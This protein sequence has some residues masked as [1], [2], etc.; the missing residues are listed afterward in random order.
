MPVFL[1]LAFVAFYEGIRPYYLR[2]ISHF[3]EE[4]FSQGYPAVSAGIYPYFWN[5]DT[6]SIPGAFDSNN[7]EYVASCF[8]KFLNPDRDFTSITKLRLTIRMSE[9]HIFSKTQS[10][11]V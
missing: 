2:L 3:S 6:I 4:H 11:G 10:N 9:R 1:S 8:P 5:N 7:R